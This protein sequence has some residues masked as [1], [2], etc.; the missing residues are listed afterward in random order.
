MSSFLPFSLSFINLQNIIFIITSVI[1]IIAVSIIAI[2]IIQI[3]FYLLKYNHKSL[4]LLQESFFSNSIIVKRNFISGLLLALE[5]EAANAI[6]KMGVFASLII[7]Q[8]E[9][10]SSTSISTTTIS[11]NFI[12]NFIIFI[13]VLSVRIVINQ[14]LRRFN[15]KI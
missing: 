4:H 14:S 8:F 5:F 13:I 9:P 12:N 15:Q 10:S 2:S 1:D 7:S 11:D 3:I 6:L